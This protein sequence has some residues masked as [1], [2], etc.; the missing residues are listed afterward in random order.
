MTDID[1]DFM[2]KKE[3]TDEEVRNNYYEHFYCLYRKQEIS[4][5]LLGINVHF[6]NFLVKL[7]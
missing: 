1:K 5:L 4:K 3:C 7:Q 2:R 6:L